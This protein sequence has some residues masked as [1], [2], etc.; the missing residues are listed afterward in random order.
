[1]KFSSI[2]PPLFLILSVLLLLRFSPGNTF[3]VDSEILF[4]VRNGR[5]DDSNGKLSD[6]VLARDEGPCNWTGIT[7]DSGNKSVISIDLTGFGLSGGFPYDLCRIRTLRNLSLSDN[8]FNGTL[9]SQSLS[10]CSHLQVL[11]ISSNAFVGELPDLSQEYRNLQVL[12][13]SF[14][15][16]SGDIPASFGSFPVLKVLNLGSNLL[17]GNIPSFL[18]HL[19]E[20]TIFSLGI[21][22]LKPSLLPSCIGNLSKLEK[23][24]ARSANLVGGIPESVGTLVRL[25]TLDLVSNRL[26]GE[27]PKSIAGLSSI[28]EIDLYDNLL[29]GELPE[30]LGNLTTLLKLDIS[31]NN[32]TGK[33]PGSIARLSLQ[34]LNLNDNYLSGEVP[35]ILGSNPNLIQLKLFNNSFT[36][37]LPR[38]LGLYSDL[39]DFD[40]STNNFTGELP[41]FLCHRSKLERIV[42]FSNRFSGKIPES[43]GECKTLNYVRMANNELSGEVPNNFWS[44]PELYHLEICNNKFQGLISPSIS[45]AWK[46]SS[47]ELNGN[48]FTGEIPLEICSLRQLVTLDLSKNHFSGSIPSCITRL[49]NLQKFDVQ[50]NMFTGELPRNLNSFTALTEMNLSTNQFNGNIPPEL[51]NLPVLTYLD[52]STNSFTGEIPFTLTELKLN[53]FNVSQNKLEGE[54]PA[55]FDHVMFI[56]SLLGNPDLCSSNLKILPPCPKTKT[57][58]V[59]VWVWVI[60]AI[61][62]VLFLGFIIWSLKTKH[63]FRTKPKRIWK[64]ITFQRVGFSEEDLFPQLTKQNLVGSG[65]SGQVYKVELKSGQ[66]LAVKRFWKGTQQAETESVFRS[67]IETLG[68]VRHGNIV[69]L[70]L[71][72]SGEDF[73]I[74]AYEYMENG[75][76]GDMLYGQKGSA[77]LL[78]WQARFM[79][80]LGAARGLAYLHHD[81]VP[82]IVH[83]DVKSNNILLDAEMNPRVADFGLAKTLYDEKGD[84]RD[85]VMSR[86]AGSC[87]YI[88]PGELLDLFLYSSWY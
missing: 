71:C 14:N 10:L 54:V 63:G 66:T 25:T 61:C 3:N 21:N 51:G 1:M 69:K 84:D 49:N 33:L 82:P 28:T 73:R 57:E 42:I 81:C 85:A 23:L 11:N 77:G 68:L 38:N 31:Q 18:C 19:S 7:C 40:V 80:A 86:I 52:L 55:G 79:I 74:L 43:Y 4:R 35:E 56:S 45:N 8:L 48:N 70:L 53:Q 76:L 75:S 6:W 29:S 27:I 9:S 13:L 26:S 62:A 44:L 17:T 34:S 58:S 50:E 2:R 32:L 59:Y 65:A 67:E 22:P 88:A 12:D 60:I 24:Y 78:N 36:G 5:L 39:E 47:I 83:R 72:C 87:G 15:N 46:L 16:F 30:G 41:R 20:L 37:K 64:V